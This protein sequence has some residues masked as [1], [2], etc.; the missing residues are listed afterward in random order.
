MNSDIWRYN[1]AYRYAYSLSTDS[2]YHNRA[3]NDI[4][5][6]VRG[7]WEKEYEKVG[8][9][10]EFKDTV[11]QAWQDFS[12]SEDPYEVYKSNFQR[13]HPSYYDEGT[14]SFDR[15]DAAYRYGYTLG[16]DEGNRGRPWSE[17]EAE[18]RQN[19][20]EHHQEHGL[21]DEIKESVRHAWN[22]L[23]GA[24]D[25]YEAARDE[26]HRHYNET[27]AGSGRPYLDY[28]P[29][30]RYGHSLVV[31]DRYPGRAWDDLEPEVREYWESEYR[32]TRQWDDYR[33]AVKHGYDIMQLRMGV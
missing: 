29:A 14:N 24:D 25:E 10:E 6:E 12:Q 22:S 11:Q 21:W 15:H 26:Y 4:E 19:W 33:D 13:Q 31:E 18:A 9:W 32:N 7:Y 23:T 27:Y 8:A 17:I 16:T 5:P 28:D 30:Y 1:A 2:R 3:W 20:A